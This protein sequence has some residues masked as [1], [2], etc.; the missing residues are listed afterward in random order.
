[1]PGWIIPWTK[2]SFPLSAPTVYVETQPEA[3]AALPPLWGSLAQLRAMQA[4]PAFSTKMTHPFFP[5]RTLSKVKV[6]SLSCVRLFAT[7]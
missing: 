4:S 7:P 5:A 1:M 2:N 3:Q 6:K